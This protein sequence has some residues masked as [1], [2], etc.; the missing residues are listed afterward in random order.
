MHWQQRHGHESVKD[1]PKETSG[2]GLA[3]W[4][5]IF[6]KAALFLTAKS[7]PLLPQNANQRAR[8]TPLEHEQ[9]KASPSSFHLQIQAP[10]LRWWLP[11][12]SSFSK[13]L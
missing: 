7:D 9:M 13:G 3:L 10:P 2:L 4:M 8:G 5:E 11:W 6:Q 12:S 1:I